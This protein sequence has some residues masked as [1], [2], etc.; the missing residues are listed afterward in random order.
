MFDSS[1]TVLYLTEEQRLPDQDE[2]RERCLQSAEIWVL[3]RR[4]KLPYLA[5]RRLPAVARS[6]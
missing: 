2:L 3:K 1:E 6:G 4:A 5:P